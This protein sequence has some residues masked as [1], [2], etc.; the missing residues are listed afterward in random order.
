[1]TGEDGKGRSD[2]EAGGDRAGLARAEAFAGIGITTTRHPAGSF[3]AADET[4][5]TSVP[6]GW[7]AGNSTDLSAQVGAVDRRGDRPVT[8]ARLAAC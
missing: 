6:G 5:R 2:G 4:G 7:A 3:I 8:Y 1:M